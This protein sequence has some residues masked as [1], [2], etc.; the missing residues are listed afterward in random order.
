MYEDS[1]RFSEEEEDESSHI[2]SFN[3]RSTLTW[4]RGQTNNMKDDVESQEPSSRMM[5]HGAGADASSML[6]RADEDVDTPRYDDLNTNIREESIQRILS[7]LPPNGQRA[8]LRTL[9]EGE[10]D[11]R[12][13]IPFTV[14]DTEAEDEDSMMGELTDKRSEIDYLLDSPIPE[15]TTK[16]LIPPPGGES[17]QSRAS[18]AGHSNINAQG[19]KPGTKRVYT[20]FGEVNRPLHEE[21]PVDPRACLMPMGKP[22]S[23]IPPS[24]QYTRPKPFLPSET[25]RVRVRK[26]LFPV[27]QAREENQNINSQKRTTVYEATM[28]R[29]S[30]TYTTEVAQVVWSNRGSLPVINE[31]GPFRPTTSTVAANP[32]K[33]YPKLL[34]GVQMFNSALSP[35]GVN[36]AMSYAEMTGAGHP[37]KS[38]DGTIQY[39]YFRPIDSEVHQEHD[40]FGTRG[41]N[42]QA[43][44]GAVPYQGYVDR[45]THGGW[46]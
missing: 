25:E 18:L 11:V 33:T 39:Q 4:G 8:F 10:T 24:Q 14:P 42:L 7:R 36:P 38:S 19:H 37:V 30:P 9:S 22:S 13:P 21:L 5:Q 3:P 6:M 26:D 32:S 15:L 35:L 41:K 28:T 23:D 40:T 34:S 46:D 43:G 2:V 44:H 12:P 27:A 20:E 1:Q 31:T 16:S 17:I 45:P 29:D